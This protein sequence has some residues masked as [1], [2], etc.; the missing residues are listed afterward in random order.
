[1]ETN[2]RAWQKDGRLRVEM[3]TTTQTTCCSSSSIILVPLQA[4]QRQQLKDQLKPINNNSNSIL[5][6]Q[7]HIRLSFTTKSRRWDSNAETF[8]TK[9]LNQNDSVYEEEEEEYSRDRRRKKRQ[10]WSD[11]SSD[12]NENPGILDQVID[13]VWLFKAFKSYGWYLPIIISSILLA[14][15][16]KAF[17][18]ALALPIGQSLLSLAFDKLWGRTSRPQRKTKTRETP[19]ARTGSNVKMEEE[20]QGERQESREGK[21]RGYQSWVVGDDGSVNK[22]GQG[23]PSFGGWEEL[24]RTR[25]IR[26]SCQKPKGSP[27]RQVEKSK[28]SRRWR[29]DTPLLLRLL[30]AVFPFLESWTKMLL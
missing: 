23:I 22:G 17:L 24:D 16:P 1:M 6:S 12:I 27:S 26:R 4:Q 30:I 3:E 10:W 19:S 5:Y 28:L 11:V 9:K 2:I 29:S 8:R 25:S 7:K 18:M 21:T 14:T 20:E 13:S 15:G